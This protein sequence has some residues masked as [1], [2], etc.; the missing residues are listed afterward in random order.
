MCCYWSWKSFA[1]CVEMKLKDQYLTLQKFG[2]WDQINCLEKRFKSCH[3]YIIWSHIPNFWRVT[4]IIP[5]NNSSLFFI[6]F[7]DT[8]P[9][10]HNSSISANFLT[11]LLVWIHLWEFLNQIFWLWSVSIFQSPEEIKSIVWMF[12]TLSPNTL[13]DLLTMVMKTL[14]R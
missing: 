13:W 1:I 8:I 4:S 10:P 11:S 6:I 7:S 14:A 5:N 2:M 12:C 9:M 3:I